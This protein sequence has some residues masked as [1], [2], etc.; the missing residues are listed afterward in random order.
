MRDYFTRLRQNVR[1]F[2]AKLQHSASHKQ[3]PM[4]GAQPPQVG[5]NQEP[6]TTSPA[7]EGTGASQPGLAAELEAMDR[8]REASMKRLQLML[9]SSCTLDN[10][11]STGDKFQDHDPAHC[12]STLT[13]H[14]HM[15][16]RLQ[17][18]P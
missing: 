10:A 9:G 16:F 3:S 13:V 18:F 12:S 2:V 5:A 14:I 7:D 11:S 6:A 1:K 15:L 17:W 8:D 4:K